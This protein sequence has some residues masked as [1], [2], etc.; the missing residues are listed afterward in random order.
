MFRI[1]AVAKNT[2][3]SAMRMKTAI[4]FMLIL[5][6][7]LP[8]LSIN[9]TGDGTAKGRLQSFISYGLGL[10]SL[11][12]SLLTIIVSCYCL[13]GEIK[14]KQIYMVLT[15]PLR[16]W[17]MILGKLFGVIML[18]LL[19]LV[20]FSS[21]IFLLTIQMPK[22]SRAGAISEEEKIVL[23]NEFFTA[24]K[25]LSI[26]FKDDEINAAAEKQYDELAKSGQL[27]EGQTKY[28]VIKEL[29][30]SERFA[31]LSAAPGGVAMWEFENVQIA[32]ASENIYV[33]FKYNASKTPADKQIVGTWYI[34]DYRQIK[35]GQTGQVQ[36]P[37]Y[38]VPTKNVVET[39]HEIFV[40]ADAVASDGYLAVAFHNE[41]SNGT[42]VIF[43]KEDGI[44]VLYK[45]GT[46]GGNYLR[47]TII[48]ASQLIFLSVLGVWLS[49]WLSFPVAI[50]FSLTVFFIGAT[51]NFVLSSF[52]TV[53]K[54]IGLIYQIVM[55]PLLWLLPKFDGKF[56]VTKYMV[57]AEMIDYG[58][59]SASLLMLLAK[60]AILTVLAM[61][62]FRKRE[63]AK[64]TV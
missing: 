57:N 6:V 10:T 15:K 21:V 18:N 9:T 11:L 30:R 8:L 29:R 45:A 12:L 20:V 19:L 51:N 46:F 2:F 58:F 38:T 48:V 55:M 16:R 27:D 42:T 63:I 53:G 31:R 23:Q 39:A 24:R 34:G 62:I 61:L 47:A 50:L 25:A 60:A 49:T 3:T 54:N 4:V 14:G 17:E 13:C 33:K 41:A 35:Y 7:L 43:P 59:L 36:T 40:P 26:T 56:S 64:I 5:I 44:K 32:D 28:E 52:S 1:F 22:T 37:I